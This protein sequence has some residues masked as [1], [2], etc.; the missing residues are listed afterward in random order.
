MMPA[1]GC[2]T[3]LSGKAPAQKTVH[4]REALETLSQKTGLTESQLLLRWALDCTKGIV[5]TSTSKRQRAQEAINVLDLAPLASSTRDKIEQAALQDGYED[6]R[7]SL[8]ATPTSSAD[9][10][11]VCSS[12]TPALRPMQCYKHPHMQKA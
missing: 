6:Q 9:T 10:R 7:V 12:S 5:V 4:L 8:Q 2:L 11:P 3:S 1:F